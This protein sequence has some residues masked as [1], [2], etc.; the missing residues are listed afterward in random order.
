LQ[1]DPR[2]REGI[3][4]ALTVKDAG[5]EAENALLQE[6]ETENDRLMRWVIAN[7]LQTIIPYKRRTKFPQIADALKY[8]NAP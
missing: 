5:P 6:L 8:K 3:I 7:A 1:H 4:R 2:I